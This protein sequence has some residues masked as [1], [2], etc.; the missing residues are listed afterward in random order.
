MATFGASGKTLLADAGIQFPA[1]QVASSDVNCL[2]DYEEG[3][4][5]PSIAFGGA[6]V[7]V[8]YSA[9]T[10]SY[11]KV[12]NTVFFRLR[13]A[14]SSKGSSTGVVTIGG[15]PF[16]IGETAAAAIFG[17]TLS[18]ISGGLIALVV[19]TTTGLNVYYTATGSTTQL[20][21]SNVA[22]GSQFYVS[23]HYTV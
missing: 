19:A 12:G 18:S 21:N 2:D 23:G 16:A 4:F 22:N 14:L 11:T 3:T 15:L 1:S 5:T 8:A 13:V 17:D 10:G 20:T 9:Q 6:A 7:G